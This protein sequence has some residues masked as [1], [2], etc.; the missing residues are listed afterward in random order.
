MLCISSAEFH[1]AD[2]KKSISIFIH[3]CM[4]HTHSLSLSILHDQ[5]ILC[6]HLASEVLIH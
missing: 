1:C 6:V 5:S 3:F 2:F 4:K